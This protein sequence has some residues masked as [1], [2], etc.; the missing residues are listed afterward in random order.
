MESGPK[1]K[2]KRRKHAGVIYGDIGFHGDVILDREILYY[3]KAE[4]YSEPNQLFSKIVN[5]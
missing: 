1:K 3:S 5:G 4:A 2:V